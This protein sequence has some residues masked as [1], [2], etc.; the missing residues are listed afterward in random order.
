VE[1]I[2]GLA[3]VGASVLTALALLGRRAKPSDRDAHQ[4]ET[5]D[6]STGYPEGRSDE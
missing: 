5:D 6:S 2:V 1:L 3:V 4:R